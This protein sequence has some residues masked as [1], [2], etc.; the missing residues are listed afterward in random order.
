MSPTTK[1]EKERMAKKPYQVAIGSLMYAAIT[2]R[3]DISF[4]VQQLSQY[5]SNPGQ[6]HWEAAKRVIRYLKGTRNH[7]LVLGGTGPL[8]L[9]GYTDADWAND[10]DRRR[11]ISGYLFSLGGGVI[12]WSSKIK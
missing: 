9:T 4:P 6:E 5:S 11:S 7:C 8:L 2:T 10:P 12:S 3:P 1:K